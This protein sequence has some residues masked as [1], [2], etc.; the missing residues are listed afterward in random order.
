MDFKDK[1]K[2]GAIPSQ[3]I[4]EMIREGYVKNADEKNIQ[5][6]S[7]DL[8]ITNE[9]YRMKGTF[10]PRLGE[11]IRDIIKKGVICSVDL[12]QPLERDGIYWIKLKEELNLPQGIYAFSSNK[13]STGRINLQ[14]RLLADYVPR[15]DRIH[16]RYKNSDFYQGSL[17]LEVIPRSFLVKLNSGDHLSQLRFFNSY[18]RLSSSELKNIYSK[19]QL[20]FNED[21][22]SIPEKEVRIRDDDATLIMTVN[23]NIGDGKIVGYKA[24]HSNNVLEYQRE[25]CYQPEEFFEPIFTPQDGQ[26]VLKRGE[27]YL[28]SAKEFIRVPPQFATEMVAYDIS[29][30]EFRTHY[31]GFFDPGF[32]YGKEGEVK[33][34]PAVLE[35]RSFDNDFIIRDGQPICKMVYDRLSEPSDLVYGED[36]LGSHYATQRGPRLSKHFKI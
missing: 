9:A 8:T 30:G 25:G 16:P 24:I 13:S 29:S 6:A 34:T 19:Y 15:F 5:P 35:L 26:L 7:L 10:L 17:W 33:G 36:R 4:R 3:K 28:L 21:G 2:I 18:S 1:Q 20:F 27:F 12:T 22:Y 32:G 14:I 23:L 11:T 31:A